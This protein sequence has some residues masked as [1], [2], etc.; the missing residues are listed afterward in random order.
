M[1][2]IV[3]SAVLVGAVL[4]SGCGSPSVSGGAGGGAQIQVAIP[5]AGIS[6]VA[7]LPFRAPTELIGVSVSDLFVTELL[8]SGRYELVERSQL[9]SVLGE[10]EVQAA[11]ET[12]G[13]WELGRMAGAEGVIIGT[14]SE[15]ETVAQR[16]R[17]IPVV[18]VNARLIDCGSGGIVWSADHARRASSSNVSLAEH[19]RCVVREMNN[20]IERGL[21]R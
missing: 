16:G 7:V 1:K 12:A 5:N 18:A 4:V 13:A 3:I 20:A 6:K 21:G 15:Y 9:S 8:R 10:A 2:G 19:G 17:A 14:V 11:L